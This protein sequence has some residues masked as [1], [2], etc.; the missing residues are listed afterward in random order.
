MSDDYATAAEWA[1]RIEAALKADGLWSDQPPP[2][3]AFEFRQAFAMDTMA[4]TQWLQYV[5][6][7]RIRQIVAERGEFPRSSMVAAQ[8][9][10]EL[11]GYGANELSRVL[12]EFD[13]WIESR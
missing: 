5:F 3:E 2:P 11:D 12:A 7:Q 8:A 9:A 1:D 13:D 10:R 4:F 6:L